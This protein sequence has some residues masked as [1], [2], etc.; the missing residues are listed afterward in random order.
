MLKEPCKRCFRLVQIRV[1]VVTLLL[2]WG[3]VPPM[4]VC[5][6]K[7]SKT[8]YQVKA[9]FLYNFARFVEWPEHKLP[10]DE[11]PIVI[12]VLGEDPFGESLDAI[13]REPVD[14]HHIIIRRFRGF[15]DKMESHPQIEEMR[16]CH[17][18]FIASDQLAFV[19][20]VA[21]LLRHDSVLTVGE[22]AGFIDRGGM[23]NFVVIDGKTCF[24]I[25]LKSSK[26]SSI[27][28][29]S[30]LSRLAVRVIKE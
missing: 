10:H 22:H 26:E 29:R 17:M 30:R 11:T 27:T 18:L 21:T 15:T 14:Q 7:G 28:I 16:Q 3:A 5:M 1:F 25:N 20:R 4:S 12:G 13:T 2:V 19:E 24:E 6:A 8:E 9:A 23:I